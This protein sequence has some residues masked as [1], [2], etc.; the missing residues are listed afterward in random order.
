MINLHRSAARR[1]GVSTVAGV[2]ERCD[3][4]DLAARGL[5]TLRSDPRVG[6]H[7]METR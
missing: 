3:P 5:A 2:T 1:R 6:E 7:D 4:T